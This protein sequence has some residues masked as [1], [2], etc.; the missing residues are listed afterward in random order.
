[1]NAPTRPRVLARHDVSDVVGLRVVAV[2]AVREI[3]EADGEL[4][5]EIPDVEQLSAAAAVTRCLLPPRLRGPELRAIRHI[6]GWTAVDLARRLG[7]RTSIETISRWE[8][9][10]VPMGGYAE[11][12]F[13]LVVCEELK[14]KALGVPYHADMIA[15]L[16]Q[17]DP[18]RS[19]PDHVLPP[20]VFERVKVRNRERR[21]L[22]VWEPEDL[23]QAA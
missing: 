12:V 18:R 10:K 15:R 9:D 19:A 21:L 3:T 14:Q 22:E 1:M 5:Y 7:E 17:I 8:N 4:S 13:R 20:M 11:K 6:V 2:G 23:P 16:I